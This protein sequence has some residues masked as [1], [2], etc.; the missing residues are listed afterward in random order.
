VSFICPLKKPAKGETSG[1]LDG[2]SQHV[3][4]VV[5]GNGRPT[6]AAESRYDED[7]GDDEGASLVER[8]TFT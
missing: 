7:T 4:D 1:L 8:H 6:T 2:E 5:I 3:S